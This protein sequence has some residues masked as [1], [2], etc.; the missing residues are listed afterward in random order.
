M[1]ESNSNLKSKHEAFL[2]EYKGNIFEF[3][4][5]KKLAQYFKIEARF[6]SSL[7]EEYL[8]ELSLYENRLRELDRNLFKLIAQIGENV[9]KEIIKFYSI[10]SL[11]EIQL[12]GKKDGLSRDQKWC[13]GDILLFLPQKT[14]PLSLKLYK[15]NSFVNTKSGG[16]KSFLSK[17]FSL[18]EF[19]EKAQ[20]RLTKN[21]EIEFMGMGQKL[22]DIAG[23]GSFSG[24]DQTWFAEGYSDRPG[25]LPE[26]MKAILYIY[27]HKLI[28]FIYEE[29]NK[30]FKED[31]SAF[32][33]SL[34]P[35][36]G[37]SDQKIEQVICSHN[38]A[39]QKI[40]TN[41]YQMN[42]IDNSFKNL[43]LLAFKDKI[44]SFEIS[45]DKSIIQIRIKPM[46]KFTVAGVK[47]NCSVKY[48][49]K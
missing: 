35:L 37:F 39:Y 30:Y 22:Y 24:F 26:E 14:L 41:F 49:D 16:I 47:I 44:A 8:N 46:N 32:K 2:N 11:K 31:P 15:K 21:S 36:V 17:Y 43:K 25:E 18:F 19:S 12:I 45:T 34:I 38:G 6:I 9:S 10:T 28:T 40:E 4:V 20:L 29:F 5:A 1:A 23:L 3:I 33:K 42:D 13:E 48:K 27:Y 7:S